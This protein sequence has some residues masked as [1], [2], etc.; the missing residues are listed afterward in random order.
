MI[1]VERLRRVLRLRRVEAHRA[2]RQAAASRGAVTSAETQRQRLLSAMPPMVVGRPQ[3]GAL[4]AARAR[5]SE[6]LH[7][8]ARSLDA[9]TPHLTAQAAAAAAAAMA[10]AVRRDRL[11]ERARIAEAARDEVRRDILMSS[12]PPRRPKGRAE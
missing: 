9:V 7:E 8:G 3:A 5:L 12:L 6:R 4:F 1:D 11:I 2:D 10:A